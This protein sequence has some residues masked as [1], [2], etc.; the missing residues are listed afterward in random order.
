MG[1]LGARPTIS[2]MPGLIPSLD[3]L[4]GFHTSAYFGRQGAYCTGSSSA[5]ATYV[6]R[7]GCS[8]A[9]APSESFPF[10]SGYFLIVVYFFF[11]LYRGSTSIALCPRPLSPSSSSGAPWCFLAAVGYKAAYRVDYLFPSLVAVFEVPAVVLSSRFSHVQLA[12]GPF[13]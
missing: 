6:G 5:T 8:P 10:L 9:G 1:R 2:V 11:S 3:D 7:Q 4:S 12:Q 13:F